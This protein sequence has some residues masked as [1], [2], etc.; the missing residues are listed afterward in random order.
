MSY[1]RYSYTPPLPDAPENSVNAFLKLVNSVNDRTSPK[2]VIE[3]DEQSL[4]ELIQKAA[5]QQKEFQD[6][7][8]KA[9]AIHDDAYY[10]EK[11]H[12]SALLAEAKLEEDP[13]YYAYISNARLQQELNKAFHDAGGDDYDGDGTMI[14]S[15]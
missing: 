5:K 1:D 2:V 13:D 11:L 14:V 3:G 8:I 10:K 7:H 15:M 9:K 6:A 12:T 4:T